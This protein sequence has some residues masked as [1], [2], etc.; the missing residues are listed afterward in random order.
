VHSS[1]RIPRYSPDLAPFDFYL[2]PKLK[3]MLKGTHFQF[4]DEV[5]S[6]TGL[7]EQGVS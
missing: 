3:S 7:A 6:K 2:F 1:A 5:K 4:V